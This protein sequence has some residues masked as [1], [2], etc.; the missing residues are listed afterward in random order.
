M[1]MYIGIE[2]LVANAIIELVKASNRK[3]VLFS[4]I[5]KYGATV[6][7]ILLEKDS[8]AVLI[9]SKERTAAFLN[10]Y[11]DFFELFTNG[12]EEG[13]RLKENITIE[14]LWKKFRGYLSID[15]MMAFTD[16]RSIA[17]LGLKKVV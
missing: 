17:E 11:S 3:E 1:S 6:V 5:N 16:D 9:L 2:D 10:D 14:Q 13:I 15:V 4:E 7:K 8:K 12:I